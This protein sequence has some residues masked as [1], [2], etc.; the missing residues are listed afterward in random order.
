MAHDSDTTPAGNLL[1]AQ[2]KAVIGYQM[3]QASVVMDRI[4]QNVVGDETGLHRLEY[5]ILMLVRANPGCTA[6]S[7]AKALAVSTPN[8]TLWLE[9][10]TSKKLLGRTPSASDRRSNHLRLTAR[11]EELTQRATRAIAAA[12]EAKLAGLSAGERAILAELLH[13]VASCRNGIES[14]R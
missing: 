5:S 2:L 6:S 12:E 10:V 1:E 13:K 9:R 7:L 14:E 11:G 8:I 4:Y 3:A